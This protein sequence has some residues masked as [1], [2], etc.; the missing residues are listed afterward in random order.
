MKEA[1]VDECA[2][3]RYVGVDLHRRRSVIVRMTPEGDRLGATVR[4]DN[5]PFALTRRAAAWGEKPEVVLEGRDRPSAQ[6]AQAAASHPGAR[7]GWPR[8]AV[9]QLARWR[10]RS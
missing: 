2:G 10:G 8:Q 3:R 5:D 4:I 9:R 1:P 6:V 7:R